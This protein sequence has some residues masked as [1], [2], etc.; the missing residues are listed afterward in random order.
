MRKK[1]QSWKIIQSWAWW[2]ASSMWGEYIF[3]YS[4][5]HM[6]CLQTH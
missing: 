5:L 1:K 4:S 2:A 6:E 3:A